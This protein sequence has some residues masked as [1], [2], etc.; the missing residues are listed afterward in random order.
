[1]NTRSPAQRLFSCAL[2]A[3]TFEFALGIPAASQSASPLEDTTAIYDVPYAAGIK[4]D[5]DGADWKKVGF[6]VEIMADMDGRTQPKASFDPSF[7]LAWDDRGLLVLL[8]VHDDLFVETAN[9]SSLWEMDSVEVFAAAGRGSR[10][11]YSLVISPGM[12]PEFPEIRT[13]PIDL[14]RKDPRVP[15]SYEA[16]RTKSANGYVLEALLPWDNLGIT[17]ERGAM[18]AFQAHANDSD[19][20]QGRFQAVWYPSAHTRFDSTAMWRIRLEDKPSP[21]EVARVRG[22][23]DFAM[24]PQVNV[25]T[26]GEFVSKPVAVMDGRSKLARGVLKQLGDYAEADL[27]FN[28]PEDEKAPKPWRVRIADEYDSSLSMP[29]ADRSRAQRVMLL[30]AAAR[31]PVFMGDKF[32]ACDFLD[33]L[34]AE[35]LIG[36]Y[37]VET[38]FYDH[39]FNLVKSAT[40]P[41]HYGAVLEIK[42]GSGRTLRRYA[43]LFRVPAFDSGLSWRY[44][45]PRLS[46]RIPDEAN[47]DPAIVKMHSQSFGTFMRFSI[48][49]SLAKGQDGAVLYAG[50][51]EAQQDMVAGKAIQAATV[52][53]D[54]WATDRQWWVQLKR[55][56]NGMEREA[57]N[58]F[59]CPRE[60]DGEPAPELRDGRLDEAGMKADAADK[61]DAVCLAWLEESQE[62]F[63]VCLARHGVVFFHKAYGTRYGEPMTVDTKSWMASISK[64]LSGTLMMT[65]VDQ[66][67]VDLDE[68]VDKYLPALRGIDVEHPLT[69]RQLYTHTSGLT[70]GIYAPRTAP[71]PDHWGDERN[72]FEE[73]VAEYY[74]ILDVGTRFS[75]GGAGYALGGKVME[76]MTGEALPHLFE[77]HLWEPLGCKHTD[78]ID[79]SAWTMSVPL[80]IA[81]FGQMMLNKGVYGTM[82]FFSEETFEKMLPVR[83]APSVFFE[84]DAEWGLG[85]AWT[86]EPGLSKRTFG[87]GAASGATLR[88][89]P[90]NDL[91]VVMTRNTGTSQHG[92]YHPE[93]IQA[94]AEGMQ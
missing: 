78:S 88:I 30:A 43:T 22:E 24:R 65:L 27:T 49:D 20:P 2:L 46:M 28:A 75:Y 11:Y 50:L 63:A 94:I 1:M 85:T 35:R 71:L 77:R 26:L 41:G 93:F 7:R 8:K 60:K 45:D 82:R 68:S 15:L 6:R 51:Y 14:R 29:D 56:L 3:A 52:Y 83:L 21:P 64:F 47:I 57:P 5:G 90:Q 73:L 17:P 54:V 67:L 4:I 25:L 91:V 10:E 12:A 84:T 53:N 37:S 59:V 74:P 48:L 42:T 44:L 79:G 16:A 81:K 23:Y 92:K 34:L 9:E 39:S 72:D 18:L 76:S 69:V 33:P 89:D 55:R 32:P 40:E 38:T 86:P 31:P 19:G 61:I 70:L 58:A 66:G 87:H 13:Q 36:K 62:S 80:D